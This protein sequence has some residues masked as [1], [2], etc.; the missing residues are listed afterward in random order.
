M[1]TFWK[2]FSA[3]S[4]LEKFITGDYKLRRCQKQKEDVYLKALN[5]D[6][7]IIPSKGRARDYCILSKKTFVKQIKSISRIL[8]VSLTYV[9][10]QIVLHFIKPM[11]LMR[12]CFY[13]LKLGQPMSPL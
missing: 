2:A 6:L 4:C 8:V 9:K 13:S 11:L 10:Q 1:T 5:S 3:S 12:M 7:I